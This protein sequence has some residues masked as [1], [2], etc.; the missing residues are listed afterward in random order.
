MSLLE[1][2]LIVFLG[3]IIG[4]MVICMFLPIFN[5]ANIVSGK[6]IKQLAQKNKPPDKTFNSSGGFDFSKSHLCHFPRLWLDDFYF[7]PALAYFFFKPIA[8]ICVAVTEQNC[9]RRNLPDKLQQVVAVRVRRQIKILH[10][11]FLRHAPRAWAENKSLAALSPPSIFRRRRIRVGVTDEGKYSAAR[12][13][14]SRAARSCAA[15]FS[16]IMPAVITKIFP[17]GQFHCFRRGLF[18]RTVNWQRLM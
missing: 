8:S 12:R 11:A 13:R 3:V 6:Q 16:L 15:V 9:A 17:P 14:S 1:P 18:S 7:R 5:L 2:L 4:G 10:I